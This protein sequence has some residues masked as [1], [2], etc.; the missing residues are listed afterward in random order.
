MRRTGPV[1]PYSRTQRTVLHTKTTLV[2][3]DT[4]VARLRRE[5]S[6]SGR[7]M[8]EV[9]E[10]ALRVYLQRRRELPEPPPL[11]AFDCGVP[12]VDVAQ[13]DTLYD[14]MERP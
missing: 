6:R 8:S 14:R 13:R 12:L 5:A 7:S 10:D 3:D 11:P 2:L 9:V 4:L 1:L